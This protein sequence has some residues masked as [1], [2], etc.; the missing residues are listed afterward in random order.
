MSGMAG[1]SVTSSEEASDPITPNIAP[2]TYYDRAKESASSVAEKLMAPIQPGE[3]KTTTRRL[4]DIP[5]G[6][7]RSDWTPAEEE[8]NKKK[9]QSMLESTGETV[10]RALGGTSR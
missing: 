8:Q 6:R 2:N 4:S 7:G 9:E 5:S 3:T 1:D 10:A